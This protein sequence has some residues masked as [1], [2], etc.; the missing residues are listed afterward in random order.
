MYVQPLDPPTFAGVQI[1]NGAAV[2]ALVVV[3]VALVVA[4]VVVVGAAVVVGH[5][6]QFPVQHAKPGQHALVQSL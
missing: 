2:V 4:L 6:P 1:L 3:V 5:V